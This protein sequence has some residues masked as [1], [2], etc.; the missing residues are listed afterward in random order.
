M[1]GLFKPINLGR[2]KERFVNSSFGHSN[3]CNILIDESKNLLPDEQEQDMLILS[4]DTG[5]SGVVEMGDDEKSLANALKKIAV[6]S[7][8][9]TDELERKYHGKKERYHRFGTANS[10]GA[11]LASN[12]LEPSEVAAHMQNYVDE[13]RH[14]IQSFTNILIMAFRWRL[15]NSQRGQMYI[16]FHENLK[17]VGRQ[18]ILSE[19]DNKL[20]AQLGFQKV[21]LVGLGGMGKTQV[22][23]KFAYMVEAKYTDYSV[24]WAT[25]ASID[26]FRNSC[27]E[28]TVALVIETCDS[29]DPRILVKV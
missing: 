28:L 1:A 2:E 13:R 22:A 21:A 14:D 27:K 12:R 8:G 20:L 26:G 6:N 24:L 15:Q 23:L 10:Q 19:L 25:A 16:P 17:F 29:D 5:L 7:K 9:V 3:I 18:D 4:I 11:I